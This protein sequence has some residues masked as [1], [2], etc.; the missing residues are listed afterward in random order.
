MPFWT[1]AMARFPTSNQNMLARKTAFK[2]KQLV[3]LAL[4][5]LEGDKG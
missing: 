3:P 2:L 1:T 4:K 5:S